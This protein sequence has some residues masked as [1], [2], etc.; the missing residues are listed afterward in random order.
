M[1]DWKC[2]ECDCVTFEEVL[3]GVTQS[4][5]ITGLE[6]LDEDTIIFEYGNTSTDGGDFDTIRFQC[7]DCG[8]SVS[9]DELQDLV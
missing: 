1:K 6:R 5:V 8:C 4:S 3:E 9:P 2:K 7:L